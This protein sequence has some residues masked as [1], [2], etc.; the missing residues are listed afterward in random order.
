M[1]QLAGDLRV[2]TGEVLWDHTGVGM[3]GAKYFSLDH[4]FLKTQ[5][6]PGDRKPIPP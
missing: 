3:F 2:V 4:W 5:F 6:D 1:L